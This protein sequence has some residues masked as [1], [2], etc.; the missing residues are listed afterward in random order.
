MTLPQVVVFD[1]DGTLTDS[2]PAIGVVLNG[3]RAE[4]GLMPLAAR[5][6]RGWISL[7]APALVGAALDLPTPATPDQVSEFR[8]RYAASRGTPADLYPGVVDMLA[9]LD[10]AGR[11]MGVCSNKP[12]ALCEKVLDETGIRRFFRAVAGGDSVPRS[13]PDP[14]HLAQTLARMQCEGQPFFYVGDSRIDAEAAAAAG[15]VFLWAA[16]GYADA[17]DLGQRGWPIAS[18][19]EIAPA[20]LQWAA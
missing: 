19:R 5:S 6:Y 14:M 7:G 20:I 11:P 12:H 2:A 10:A 4:R 9:E 13:K 18:P 1:L 8:R 17:G 16:Y 15:A 3:L